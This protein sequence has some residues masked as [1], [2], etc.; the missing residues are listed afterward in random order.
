MSR[1]LQAFFRVDKGFNRKVRK[2]QLANRCGIAFLKKTYV[3][4]L[5]LN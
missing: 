2:K 4:D 1:D 5:G 3:R